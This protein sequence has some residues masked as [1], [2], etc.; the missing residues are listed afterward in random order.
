[1]SISFRRHVWGS[2]T[3]VALVA[4][5]LLVLSGVAEAQGTDSVVNDIRSANQN[6]G[7]TVPVGP[8]EDDTRFVVGPGDSLWT[9]AEDRLQPDASPEQ[10]GYETE[11]IVELNRNL[12]GS[13]PD[14]ILPGQELLLAPV[15]EPAAATETTSPE[16][17]AAAEPVAAE[18]VAA[19][20]V[21]P[22]VERFPTQNNVEQRRLLGVGTI[23]LTFVVAILMVWKPPMRRPQSW[24]TPVGDTYY[25]ALPSG[26]E[27]T[28]AQARRHLDNLNSKGSSAAS[29]PNLQGRTVTPTT[30]RYQSRT[31]K[32]SRKPSRAASKPNLQG[33]RARR[34]L[35]Q[36]VALS[37]MYNTEIR[38][39]LRHPVK[40]RAH[41]V[42]AR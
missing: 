3:G 20:P 5:T 37:D 33:R 41:G 24:K 23:V 32:Q 12:L 30:V 11:R 18:P 38:S 19:E 40:S 39:S 1:L 36:V 22:T 17:A 15:A 35:R 27:F 13:N 28:G 6:T 14:M 21:A 8:S 4:A 26:S 10:I 25:P 34:P 9:I 29:K 42:A 31:R 2:V 7:V 16:P